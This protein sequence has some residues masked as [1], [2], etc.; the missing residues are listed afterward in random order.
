M[1]FATA[2][3]DPLRALPSIPNTALM[4]IMAGRLYRKTLLARSSS[5]SHQSSSNPVSLS[6]VGNYDS[7]RGAEPKKRTTDNLLISISQ[8]VDATV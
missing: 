7:S 2:V 3:P 8:T 5:T 6:L 4:N 1:L